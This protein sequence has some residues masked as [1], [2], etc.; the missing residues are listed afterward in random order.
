MQQ[1]QVGPGDRVVIHGLKGRAEL[2]GQSAV[3]VG[4]AAG[5]RVTVKL[6]SGETVA[7]KQDNLGIQ[8]PGGA[9]G[10]GGGGGMPGAGG[11]PGFGGGM[12]G[13]M[14]GMGGMPAGMPDPAQIQAMITQAVDTVVKTLKSMGVPVPANVSPQQLAG[15]LA[16][17]I[18]VA[19]YLLTRIFSMTVLMAVGMVAGWGS[20][21]DGG[22]TMLAGVSS[23][24]SA[25]VRRPLPRHAVL[26]VLCIT[27]AVGGNMLLN[28]RGSAASTAGSSGASGGSAHDAA[29]TQAI[30]EAYDQG[31]DDGAAGS[32][33]RPPKHIPL[34]SFDDPAPDGGSQK[35][36]GFGFSQILKYGMLAYFVYN[37]GKSPDGRGW[38][39][40]VAV[41][42]AKANP[43]Q[44]VMMLVMFTFS[45]FMS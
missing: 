36:S 25:V 1:Q 7:L 14:P 32:D 20:Q 15:G 39:P 42:N 33:R 18:A 21:T 44:A 6:D 12:P 10:G 22:R 11:M 31:Y 40:Q 35:S 34:P 3:L 29:I 30:R 13:G 45:G 26:V 38:D 28:G 5:G 41:A 17:G 16:L 37:L 8:Q 4:Q 27:V 9:G 24:I 19:L 43:I 2:N 23:K